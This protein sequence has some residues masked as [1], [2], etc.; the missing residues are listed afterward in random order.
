M[1]KLVQTVYSKCLLDVRAL[2]IPSTWLLIMLIHLCFSRTMLEET[3]ETQ[4]LCLFK[5][6][7]PQN[8]NIVAIILF[9]Q[10]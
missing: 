5:I 7:V 2:T 6:A 3:A 9:H 4:N 10:Y 8:Y 1:R